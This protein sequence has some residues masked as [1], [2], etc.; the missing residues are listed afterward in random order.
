MLKWTRRIALL[1]L[2]L[3]VVALLV[4]WWSMRGSLAALDGEQPL[5]GLSA[6]VTVQRDAL[7]VVTI[8][9]ASETD[10]VRAL[11]FVHA[12]ERYFEMDLMRRSSAGELS[13][14]FG[15]VAVGMDKARR[16]HRMRARAMASLD[17]FAGDRMPQL[18]AY[19]NGV[20]DGLGALKTR[21]WPYL[22]LRQSPRPW[23]VADSALAGYAMYF[24]LQDADNVRELGLWKIRRQVPPALYALLAHDGTE[25]DAPL[26]GEPRGNAALPTANQV[27]LRTLPMPKSD[28]H[29]RLADKGTPGSNNWAVAGALTADG[30]AIVADDMHLGL[31][32]PNI[33]F[34]V[35]LRYPDP[36]APGGKVDV[37]GFSL[38]GL[39][40]I[41][42]GSNGHLAWGFTNSYADT[43][44]WYPVKPCG[45]N[46]TS[47]TCD[48][49]EHHTETIRVAGADPVTLDVQDTRYGPIIHPARDKQPALALR[50]VAHQPGALNFGL[51]DFASAGDLSA[52][53]SVAQRTATPAQNLVIADHNGRIAWRILGPLPSRAASCPHTL[54]LAPSAPADD[55]APQPPGGCTPWVISSQ[56][57]PVLTS[58]ANHR[59][60]TANAR[61][62]DGAALARVGDGGY[63]LGARAKQIR[64]G[65]LAKEQ[66]T[67]KDLLAVQLDDRALFLER[68]W[69]LLQDEA[70]RQPANASIKALAEA[71]KTW[72][73]VAS[74]DSVSYRLV[75]AWRLAV[76]ARIAD[77]LTAP[78]QAAQGKDFVMPDL[79][80]LE[81]VVWPLLEQRP[82]HLLSRRYETWDALLE[83][84][85]K[86][87]R[88]DLAGQGPLNER[89]W[90]ERNTAKICHP[91]ANAL[92]AV[93]KP[94]L[95]MP[96]EPLAGDGAM[97]RVQGPAFGA[98]ERMVVSPGHEAD[99]IIH[100]PG[101]QS[102][103]PMSPFWGA[104][105]D[106]WV[107]G[108]PT[109]FLP[110]DARHTLTLRPATTQPR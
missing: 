102:G 69:R 58:P 87:V 50:W 92:P 9:A 48:A 7:G 14:L 37:S 8:D 75:R 20:N 81:G 107:H 13:E 49:V 100:M 40:A 68:W 64:D 91:L 3:V 4:A 6:P 70:K 11:G 85:A 104:G 12:Q 41:I 60:W 28:T 82:P 47:E 66:F 21:P 22:L 83:D 42:V 71:G 86:E 53:L 24:D 108:R 110:G 29:Q 46:D 5:P 79:P 34:R 98:S 88:D 26:Q 62:L 78:A 2:A 31:R 94:K 39:P 23:E 18:Q 36:H 10:A 56:L 109:P 96:G 89:R 33:W 95:C 99:G 19:A 15:S 97:P 16:M 38:P 73:G 74:V 1:L 52:A 59:L 80:Q 76:H 51:S 90:G 35:R 106:D 61:V 17:G 105:H 101:G 57:S 45:K 32:A 55:A 25:W 63:A 65:L 67:E 27:D 30:R 93:L 54:E 43:A 72:E 77:G 84:A 44:D 103:H